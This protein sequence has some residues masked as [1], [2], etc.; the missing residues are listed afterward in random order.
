[1][2][3]S[4]K[5][6]SGSLYSEQ[7][8]RRLSQPN[9]VGASQE[10]PARSSFKRDY[11][12]LLHSASFRRL[13]GKTQLFPSS[14]SD[15]F[16]NRL[17]HS[18]EV[19][20]IADAIARQ[21]NCMDE[22]KNYPIDL[23][24]VQTASLAHDLGHP[25]FGHNGEEVLNEK[26]QGAGGFE[27]NAQTLRLLVKIEKRAISGNGTSLIDTSGNDLRLGL[28]LCVRTIASVLKYDSII[29]EAQ[30]ATGLQKGFYAS[31]LEIINLVKSKI[32]NG[33][34]Q[35]PGEFKTIECQIM[36]LA[37]DIAYSTYDLEDAFKC[38]FLTPLKLLTYIR[39]NEK[40]LTSRVV[41]AVKRTIPDFT[42]I[43]LLQRLDSLFGPLL[44]QAFGIKGYESSLL[45]N[46]ANAQTASDEH[47]F[48]GYS[49]TKFTSR[50]VDDALQGVELVSF[51]KSIPALSKIR[52][53]NKQLEQ[54]EVLKRLAFELVI[55]SNSIAVV[56]RRGREIVEKIFDVLDG[57]GGEALL[58]D[59]YREL[60]ESLQSSV[61]DKEAL[62]IRRKRLICDFVSGMTD[63]Y[64]VEFY[65]RLVS[66]R[67]TTLFKPL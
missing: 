3:K 54:V 58:P 49:R 12:R 64:A 32:T 27:G 26:M 21:L 13:Q 37:D 47:A 1:M 11:A 52:M 38:G 35:K 33:K 41:G 53:A 29:Q 18:L 63:R 6:T 40:G 28:D 9:S 30:G 39:K 50:L 57:P 60:F 62:G 59:D 2:R 61:P 55:L 20:Q 23:D 22:F 10:T 46:I 48:S 51:N 19:A 31:E 15:F 42:E 7:D 66:E 36:D 43:K 14:E 67:P 16:R 45:D 65:G 56:N 34:K 5:K 4:P 24:L 25:P 44:E 17:T 8:K